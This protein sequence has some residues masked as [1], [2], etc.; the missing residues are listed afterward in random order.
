VLHPELA[1]AIGI[2]R[3][4][5]E[6][7]LTAQLQHS[8][9]VPMLDSGVIEAADNGRLPWYTMPYIEGESLRSIWSTSSPFRACGPE[10]SPLISL[11]PCSTRWG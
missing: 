1:G 5:R 11:V 9:I 10:A 8:G 7:R 3:F 6:I 2:D 4:L